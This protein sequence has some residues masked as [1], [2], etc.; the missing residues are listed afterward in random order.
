MHAINT[1]SQ[2]ALVS[3]TKSALSVEELIDAVENQTNYL[4]LYNEKDIDL[5]QTVSV[6]K[7]KQPVNEM[8]Q[9]AFSDTEINFSFSEDY[10]SLRKKAFPVPTVPQQNKK[11]ITGTVTDERGDPVIGANVIEKGTTNGVITDINGNFSLSVTE[12]AI[13]EIS[14]IGYNK[15]E[16][17]TRNKTNPSI[18]LTEDSK[19]LEEVIVIGY[20]AVKKS[21]L[22]GAVS[23][24]DGEAIADRILARA[25]TALQG[26]LAGVAVR[27]I[28]G[29]PGED[30]QIRVRGAASINANSDPLYVVDGT[31]MNTLSGVNPSD[32]SSIEVLKD[33]ASAAIYGSRGSNGVVIVTTKKGTSGKPKVSFSANFG[34]QEIEKR[35]DVLNAVE[36]MEFKIKY[37]DENYLRN[38]QSRGVTSA[39]INDPNVAR[40]TNLGMDPNLDIANNITLDDRWFQYVSESTKAS[41][42]FQATDEKLNLLDW[43]DAIYR[44]AVIQ[45]YGISLSGGTENTKYLFSGGYMNQPGL[46]VGTNYERFAAR[47]NIESKITGFLTAGMT[48]APTY[49]KRKGVGLANGKDQQAHNALAAVP[50]SHDDVGYMV[51]VEPNERYRYSAGDRPS[52][53]A[54]LENNI[55]N[56]DI[57]RVLGTAFVRVEPLEGLKVELSGS[58]NYYDYDSYAYNFSNVT[59]SWTLGEGASSSSTH[60][61]DRKIST[62]VQ[63]LI[64]YDKT[65]NRHTIGLMLGA[66]NEQLNIG[67]FTDQRYNKPFPNDAVTGSFDGTTIPVSRTLVQEG[68][69]NRIVSFFGRLQY[70]YADRYLLTGSLRYDGGSVFG[71]NNKWGIFPALSGA[72]NISNEKFFKNLEIDQIN[73]LKLRGSYGVTGNNSISNTAGYATMQSSIYAGLPGYRVNTIANSDLGW[74]M[75]HSTD[76]ALDIALL[77][78]RIQF[79][80]DWYTKETT[81]LLYQIPVHG[82]SGFSTVWGNLGDVKNEGFELEISSRNLTGAFKWNT[83]FNFSYNKNEVQKLGA[84]DTPVYWSFQS[85][86]TPSNIL[87][88]GEAINSFYLY[89]SIGVWKTQKEIDDYSALHENKTIAFEGKTIKPGDIRYRDVN[90]DG[91]FDKDNDRSILGNPF[92]SCVYG[93]TNKFEYKNF[94]LSILLTAQ[95]GGKIY[96]LMGRHLNNPGM[97]ADINLMGNLKNSWWSETDQ[98]DGKTPYYFSTTTGGIIDSRWLYS[99]DYLRVKNFTLG[100]KIPVN[101]K[102]M[103]NARVYLSIENL[104][105]WDSYDGGYSPETAN[106]GS[107]SYGIDYGG[108]PTARTFTI[109]TNI[110]F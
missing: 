80:V 95:T 73:M 66:S 46:A 101:S 25:E 70:N 100:Y 16:V 34:F 104:F 55:N 48:L 30:M 38:A 12:N 42:S 53:L 75:T 24:M 19:T 86:A 41:H 47:T 98:G 103:S 17:S 82:A 1:H 83:S 6:N 106:T 92:P 29:E 5:N 84:T 15:Q 91:E 39:S 21:S 67:F 44:N 90:N 13:L 76:L 65:I 23:K 79:S 81:D 7:K 62:L 3:I 89:E 45:E 97:G 110:V 14:Y 56:N 8:L 57:V 107:S 50:V 96:G 54:V 28:S 40:L 11:Q 51:L 68:T 63:G 102:I 87:K 60:Q 58:V 37:S 26:T 72:W 109:G 61:T 94:D 43:Q 71:A 22:T 20:G 52:P 108:Y 99:S 105:R 2:T 35:V 18:I 74:E 4:F 88:V 32:I 27:T 93:L 49:I 69:P 33:A 59:T 36:W 77:Y 85:G 10:I 78:N 9:Q 31:P 64:N